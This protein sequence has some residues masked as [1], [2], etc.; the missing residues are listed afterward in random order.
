M[1]ME[2]TDGAGNKKGNF[3]LAARKRRKTMQSN[4][5]ITTE[6]PN[7]NQDIKRESPTT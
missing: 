6:A 1:Y 5:L 4:F 7:S 3:T 2:Y